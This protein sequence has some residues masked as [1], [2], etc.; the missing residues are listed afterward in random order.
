MRHPGAKGGIRRAMP[1]QR[2]TEMRAQS[3]RLQ[4]A[5]RH[6]TDPDLRLRMAARSFELAQ[7]AEQLEREER[8][9]RS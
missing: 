5:A 6:E 8:D 3:R 9:G 1:S 2:I 7:L 4:D